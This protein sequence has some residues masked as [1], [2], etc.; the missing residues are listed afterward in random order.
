MLK[1]FSQADKADATGLDPRV[2]SHLIF[3][4]DGYFGSFLSFGV[5]FS[6][7][8]YSNDDV[9]EMK[10]ILVGVTDDLVYEEQT[11]LPEDM[12]FVASLLEEY[13]NA[14]AHHEFGNEQT[15]D[16]AWTFAQEIS[17]FVSEK[18][19]FDWLNAYF[20]SN[21][22]FDVVRKI[23]IDLDSFSLKS[24]G[25]IE[26]FDSFGL[27]VNGKTSGGPAE[28][29]E[30][31]L[32]EI[33]DVIELYVDLSTESPESEEEFGKSAHIAMILSSIQ[34]RY[35][36]EFPYEMM[37]SNVKFKLTKLLTT[38]MQDDSISDREVYD[39]LRYVTTWAEHRAKHE[40]DIL[41]FTG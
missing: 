6:N 1:L 15:C 38:V 14:K 34:K 30:E 9:E 12:F 29:F 3:G 4:I 39:G 17:G 40:H 24:D 35:A 10:D 26:H 18:E 13:Y 37:E 21:S 22:L 41:T 33:Q 36:H 5:L 20:V 25:Q 31:S 23:Y 2:S 11:V 19:D 7:M 32:R 28:G 8:S 16:I 27:D